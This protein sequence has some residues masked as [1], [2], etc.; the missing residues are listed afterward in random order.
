MTAAG[1]DAAALAGVKLNKCK[2][3]VID[4]LNEPPELVPAGPRGLDPFTGMA[5]IPARG[6]PTEA[7]WIDRPGG[8]GVDML[9]LKIMAD[10]RVPAG[11]FFIDLKIQAT[12][13][14]APALCAPILVRGFP[15]AA[16]LTTQLRLDCPAPA[17]P[18]ILAPP[19]VAYR[20][21]PQNGNPAGVPPVPFT[22]LTFP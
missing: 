21:L 13:V 10:R 15:P 11:Q 17:P 5:T 2:A 22:R 7:Q 18:I 6:K 19:P 16:N 14:N 12:T 4:V 9:D 8:G 3:A 1:V 20:C